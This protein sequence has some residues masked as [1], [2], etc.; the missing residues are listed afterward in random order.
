MTN[1][2]LIL[3]TDQKE[4]ERGIKD[5]ELPDL[6]IYAPTDKSE[7]LELVPQANIFLANPP[8]ALKYLNQAKELKWMQ[9][10]FAGVDS[11]VDD[12][13]RR[14]Y[15][16]TNAKG[17]Y[18][19]P[20][21]EYVFAYI[22]GLERDV[23]GYFDNQKNKKWDQRSFGI[24]K[25]KTMAVMGTGSIGTEIARMAKAFN[26]KAIGFRTEDKPAENFDEIYTL[27]SFN[28]FLSKADYIVSILPKTKQTTHLINQQ[29]IS[30]M[31]PSAVFINV[32]R[33]NAVDEEALASALKDNKIAGAVLDVFETEPLPQDS[34]FWNLPNAIVTPHISGYY[35]DNNIFEI[36]EE[37]YNRFINGKELIN[38]V[39]FEKGY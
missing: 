11:L 19:Q 5:L 8:R 28:A 37:N 21:A 24:L 18:G 23:M 15:I 10:T 39:D 34:P 30:K 7:V 12:G 9:A 17:F 6:E 38:K 26:M 2:L 3:T 32:G 14:D 31:K 13:L 16:L 1:K 4:V 20:I 33:G 29:T 25:G 36:F 22:L 27:K 35:L